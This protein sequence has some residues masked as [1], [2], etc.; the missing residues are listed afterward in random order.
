MMKSTSGS[1]WRFAPLLAPILV[2]VGFAA[3]APE[4]SLDSVLAKMD[5]TAAKFDAAQANFT[6]TSYNRVVNEVTDTQTGKVYFRRHGND[7]KMAAD[8]D[9][10][11]AQQVIFSDGMVHIYKERL[12]TE[13]VYDARAH[14]EDFETFLVLGFLSSGHE[15]CKSFDVKYDGEEKIDGAGTAKLELV[16]K[17]ASV[18]QHFPE[19]VL[20]IDLEQGVSRQQQ[21]F[22]PDGDYRLAKY[23][24]IQLGKKIPR[25]AFQLK[26]HGNTKITNH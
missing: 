18:K 16:P 9:P 25:N 1:R 3:G 17:S 7:I 11:Q 5:Q 22:E 20:W 12:G 14:Q 2:L 6:W 21:L 19:I 8:I 24:N 4:A 26:T 15:V 10:P 23:S 13:D